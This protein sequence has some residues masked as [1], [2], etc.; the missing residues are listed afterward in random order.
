V[1]GLAAELSRKRHGREGGPRCTKHER[2]CRRLDRGRART[3]VE[4]WE[5]SRRARGLGWGVFASISRRAVER[6]ELERAKDAALARVREWSGENEGEVPE[7]W[8]PETQENREARAIELLGEVNRTG[9]SL[10]DAEAALATPDGIEWEARTR[11]PAPCVD[12]AVFQ[13]KSFPVREGSKWHEKR[14]AAWKERGARLDA[15]G[16]RQM[17]VLCKGC[18]ETR[19]VVRVGCGAVMICQS[20]RSA[21]ASRETRRIRLL[22]SGLTRHA[23]NAG[24]VETMRRGQVIRVSGWRLA[25]LTVPHVGTAEFRSG[26]I[27]RAWP[28]FLRSMNEYLGA[29]ALKYERLL[30]RSVAEFWHWLRKGEVT[31]GADAEGHWH[32]HVLA[33]GPYLDVRQVREWWADAL[34]R[35]GVRVGVSID[36]KGEAR[37][38]VVVDVR[39]VRSI[40]VAAEVAK[41]VAKEWAKDGQEMSGRLISEVWRWASGSRTTQT[42]RGLSWFADAKIQTCGCCLASRVV[43]KPCLVGPIPVKPAEVWDKTTPIDRLAKVRS[44]WQR[45]GEAMRVYD[46][47]VQARERA[48]ETAVF[49]AVLERQVE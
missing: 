48:R 20:C 49:Y 24:V 23:R 35:S 33:F 6:V 1:G 31:I 19:G 43:P 5:T 15:C 10:E 14:A 29:A 11:Y 12:C 8:S 36:R 25:T 39:R 9:L 37:S 45:Y 41:Y 46:A 18:G 4:R 47:A 44:S 42:S 17:F 3:L 34:R 40:D 2:V 27:A 28:R 38:D 7:A 21:R 26:V 13:G 22:V 32:C 16:E 30:G